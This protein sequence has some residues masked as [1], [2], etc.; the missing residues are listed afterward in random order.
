M[1]SNHKQK[2]RTVGNGKG[3]LYRYNG[4]WRASVAFMS[5]GKLKRLYRV[6]RTRQEAQDA[7]NELLQLAGRRTRLS[8]DAEAESMTAG[9]LFERWMATK[10]DKA[11]STLA[12]YQ[13]QIDQ[14]LLPAFGTWLLDDITEDEVDEWR[15]SCGLGAATLQKC[16]IVL[17][18]S[19]RMAKKKRWLEVYPLEFTTAPGWKREKIIKPF[20]LREAKLILADQNRYRAYLRLALSVGPRPGEM[21]ALQWQDIEFQNSSQDA[22]HGLIRINRSRS[23]VGGLVSFKEPKT[24]AGSR[25][26]AMDEK[27]RA[28]LLEH[29]KLMLKAGRASRERLVFQSPLGG[30]LRRNNFSS[31][32]WQPLL[33]RLATEHQADES[34]DFSP[35]GI[36]HCRHT[37]ATLML[38]AGV[39]VH[40]V[41]GILGH[42]RSSY[43]LDLYAHLLPEQ[44]KAAVKARAKML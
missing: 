36:H 38:G 6:R 13:N 40:V 32:F 37:A 31:N 10:A 2:A 7:L 16:F 44:Q 20:S 8:S 26:I 12:N 34:L 33:I 29:R 25:V 5:H 1:S 30:V 35:R 23:E 43:T 3:S 14:H 41:S 11:E 27:T 28:E 42:Q 22:E 21:A 39:P 18:G 9:Q 17:R 4:K 15:D 19:L 24:S